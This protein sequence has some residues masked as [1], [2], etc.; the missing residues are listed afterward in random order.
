MINSTP[1]PFFTDDIAIV[2]HT[3]SNEMSDAIG[4]PMTIREFAERVNGPVY[5]GTADNG[6]LYAASGRYPNIQFLHGP[7]Q[8]PA[9][10]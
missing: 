5:L 6:E 2:A 4:R 8:V 9:A 7:E 1:I 3:T 10:A